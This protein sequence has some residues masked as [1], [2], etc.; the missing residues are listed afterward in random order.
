MDFSTAAQKETY[1]RIAPWVKELFG[2]FAKAREDKP[3]F[4]VAVGSA[5]AQLMV[6]PWGSDDAT[7]TTRSWVVTD[8]ELTPDLMRF[9]LRKN[10]EVRFGAF[11]VDDDDDIFFE[12][13]ISGATCDKEEIEHSVKAVVSVADEFD[14]QIVERWGGRRARDRSE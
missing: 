2:V 14:D 10:N 9:L 1:E 7:I 5:Q 13:T 3:A 12:H 6:L 8:V 4:W 11:G